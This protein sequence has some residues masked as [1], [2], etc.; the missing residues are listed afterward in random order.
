MGGCSSGERSGP[1]ELVRYESCGELL[2]RLRDE[3]IS[4][5]DE[6]TIREPVNPPFDPTPPRDPE[7]IG[8]DAGAPYLGPPVP[9]PSGPRETAAASNPDVSV[10]NADSSPKKGLLTYAPAGTPGT[11][12]RVSLP[13]AGAYRVIAS[14][15][16]AFAIGR[17]S[18]RIPSSAPSFGGGATTVIAIVDLTPTTPLLTSTVHLEGRPIAAAL[19]D[20]RLRVVLDSP[21]TRLHLKSARRKDDPKTVRRSNR[22]KIEASTIDRWLPN[23]SVTPADGRPKS[24]RIV[25]CDAFVPRLGAVTGALSA[26]TLDPEDPDP[27]ART[28]LLG[29]RTGTN[30]TDDAIYVAR[31]ELEDDAD[32]APRPEGGRTTVHAFALLADS[33]THRVSTGS[34]R[35]VLLGGWSSG[36]NRWSIS[37]SRADLRVVTRERSLGSMLTHLYVLRPDGDRLELRGAYSRSDVFAG[38]R[39]FDHAAAIVQFPS[40]PGGQTPLV[41]LSDA[42]DP[43]AGGRLPFPSYET[44]MD[45][46]TSDTLLV[47]IP[48]TEEDGSR[49]RVQLYDIAEPARP[50][51]IDEVTTKHY[52]AGPILFDRDASILDVSLRGPDGHYAV[53][54][55]RGITILEGSGRPAVKPPPIPEDDFL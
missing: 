55:R 47:V 39:F 32:P 49:T 12:L 13:K 51:L 17:Q 44:F 21:G 50:R 52:R 15:R 10:T 54:A 53:D 23:Y 30:V 25:G 34:V 29:S 35:G 37:P 43:R 19:V 3:A 7:A 42:D 6:H 22:A 27:R 31:A 1:S 33:S 46:P 2:E 9:I 26:L 38:V 28:A 16:H 5:V 36:L 18:D 20:G 41:D 14:R 48:R 8:G 4:A 40:G 45:A 11:E 24:G